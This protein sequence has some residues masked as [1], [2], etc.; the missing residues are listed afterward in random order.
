MR[1]ALFTFAGLLLLAAS[2]VL[3]RLFSAGYPAAPTIALAVFA[4]SWLVLAALNLWAGVAHA[5]YTVGQ[6]LPIFALIFIVPV[7]IGA[8]LRWR[9]L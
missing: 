8:L 7:A 9:G 5:G 1:T 4:L 6:E 2:V 3:G